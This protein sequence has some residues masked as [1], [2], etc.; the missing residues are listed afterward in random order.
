MNA[1]ELCGGSL[2]IWFIVSIFMGL[3][4]FYNNS[5]Q[6]E[7][8]FLANLGKIRRKSGYKLLYIPWWWGIVGALLILLAIFL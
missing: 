1:G 4:N 6:D 7:K 2:I 3:K 5:G 8:E